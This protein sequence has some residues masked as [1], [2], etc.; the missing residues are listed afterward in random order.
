MLGLE[1]KFNWVDTT[2]PDILKR[3]RESSGII[4]GEVLTVFKDRY[5]SEFEESLIA[6]TGYIVS[7]ENKKLMIIHPSQLTEIIS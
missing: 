3:K 2:D 1:I 4:E 7:L 6:E 5:D